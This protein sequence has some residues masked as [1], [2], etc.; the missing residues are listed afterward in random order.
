MSVTRVVTRKEAGRREWFQCRCFGLGGGE[1]DEDIPLEGFNLHFLGRVIRR[2]T[3]SLIIH[4]ETSGFTAF[5]GEVFGT[6]QTPCRQADVRI[7]HHPVKFY[8]ILSNLKNTPFFSEEGNAES[9]FP[10]NLQ[11]KGVMRTVSILHDPQK[12]L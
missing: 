4:V 2:S 3:C 7:G 9:P 1:D 12:R 10:T 5:F 6:Q 11:V 8:E